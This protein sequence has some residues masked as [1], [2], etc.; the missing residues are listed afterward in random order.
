M[1]EGGNRSI[2]RSTCACAMNVSFTGR[3]PGNYTAGLFSHGQP[4]AIEFTTQWRFG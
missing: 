4:V 3:S 2:L 1:S